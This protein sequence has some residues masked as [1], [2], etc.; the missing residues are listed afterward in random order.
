MTSGVFDICHAGHLNILYRARQLGDLLIVG[1]VTD[2]GT[3]AYKGARPAEPE[4][5]RLA[6]IRRLG[7]AHVVELQPTTDPTPLI[8]RFHPDIYCHADGDGEWSVLQERVRAAGCPC[9]INLP[10][11]PD[12]SSTLLRAR[13]G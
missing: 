12:I 6:A 4:H 8:E 13:I 5:A 3:Q 7:L 2:D 1:V 11:T 9:Y 10:Y